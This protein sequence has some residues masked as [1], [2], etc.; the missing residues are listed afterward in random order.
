[1][2]TKIQEKIA[3][4]LAKVLIFVQNGFVRSMNYLFA[5][6]KIKL[7]KRWL[8]VFCIASGGLSVYFFVE[9]VVSRPAFNVVIDP[10]RMPQHFDKSGDE[11]KENSMPADIY[12]QIQEYRRYMD[13]AGLQIRHGME[14]SMRILEQIYL[15]QN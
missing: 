14:D 7:M 6:M 15:Q 2:D 8:M 3:G 13:S 5:G 12:L 4:R 9:A 1:M 11:V 10:L